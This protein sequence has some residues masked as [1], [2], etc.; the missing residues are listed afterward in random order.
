[1]LVMRA[2]W[3]DMVIDP[4]GVYNSTMSMRSMWVDNPQT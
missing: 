1:M 4:L 3:Y 2:L